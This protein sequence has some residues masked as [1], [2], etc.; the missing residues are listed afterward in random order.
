MTA[1]ITNSP[2]IDGLA[3]G[4]IGLASLWPAATGITQVSVYAG[5]GARASAMNSPEMTGPPRQ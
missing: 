5:S 3:P 2:S 1:S 4:N